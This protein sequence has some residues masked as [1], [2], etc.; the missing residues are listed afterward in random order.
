L[1]AEVLA[2]GDKFKVIRKRQTYEE[3][4]APER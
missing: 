3:M 4:I 2:D 1:P